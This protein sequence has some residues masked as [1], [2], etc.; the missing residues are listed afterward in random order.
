MSEIKITGD[1]QLQ[2]GLFAIHRCDSQTCSLCQRDIIR[3][4]NFSIAAMCLQDGRKAKAL[5]SLG[6]K[7]MFPRHQAEVIAGFAP[8]GVRNADHRCDRIGL[9]QP[10]D[11]ACNDGGRDQRARRVMDEDLVR[12]GLGSDGFQSAAHGIL[13]GRAAGNRLRRD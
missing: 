2:I 7:Q 9:V 11:D 12:F 6:T 4:P 3:M 8:E 10:L 13:P 1:R 5:G